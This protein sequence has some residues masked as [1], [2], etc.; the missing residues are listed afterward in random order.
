MTTVSSID[1]GIM[2][3]IGDV[4][5]SD[6]LRFAFGLRRSCKLIDIRQ[7][8]ESSGSMKS[9]YTVLALKKDYGYMSKVPYDSRS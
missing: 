3:T 7:P 1:F 6:S 4:L 9:L 2:L 5:E 8:I